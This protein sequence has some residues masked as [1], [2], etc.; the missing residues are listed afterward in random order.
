MIPHGTMNTMM[1]MIC[2]WAHSSDWV[3]KWHK[4]TT[5]STSLWTTCPRLT[6]Q[7]DIRLSSQQVPLPHHTTMSLTPKYHKVV[8]HGSVI[9]RHFVVGRNVGFGVCVFV[10]LLILILIILEVPLWVTLY[11]LSCFL[12]VDLTTNTTYI[13][14]SLN[15]QNNILCYRRF[16]FTS[17]VFIRTDFR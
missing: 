5:L 7:C 13:N 10:F 15:N 2:S 4:H 8:S 12:H 11:H 1:K 6:Q 3:N 16:D 17:E 14:Y 9:V